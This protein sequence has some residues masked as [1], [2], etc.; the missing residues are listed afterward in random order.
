[1]ARP[2]YY[3]F[4]KQLSGNGTGTVSVTIDKEFVLTG[5]AYN[6]TGA[7]KGL[8]KDQHKDWGDAQTRLENWAGTAQRPSTALIP[9]GE[10]RIA[11]Q[12]VLT[13]DLTDLSGSTNDVYLVLLG[14]TP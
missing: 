6:A 4:Y 12:T 9:R 10:L 1:M 8:L 11:P 13:L 14:Y 7:V 2:Y 5:I 3:S